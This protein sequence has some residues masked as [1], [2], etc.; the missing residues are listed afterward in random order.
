MIRVLAG[1]VGQLCVV[2]RD[3][4]HNSQFIQTLR[5]LQLETDGRLGLAVA[6]TAHEKTVVGEDYIFGGSMN[7][8]RSGLTSSE[9]HV[10]LR[11]DRKAAASR[12]LALQERDAASSL[13]RATIARI[14]GLVEE[15]LPASAEDAEGFHRRPLGALEAF[16]FV[17]TR[18]PV[19]TTPAMIEA[20]RGLGYDDLGILDLATA[21]A[22]ANQ[23]ARMHRLLALPCDILA[24]TTDVRPTPP[25]STSPQPAAGSA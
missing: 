21:V 6:P 13:S 12:R 24:P 7:L 18:Y 4:E 16:V 11:V 2:V 22:D 23:W 10:L 20:L 14:H 15:Y 17:G 9:E 5:D 19:R 8:T 25:A 1:R 3:V